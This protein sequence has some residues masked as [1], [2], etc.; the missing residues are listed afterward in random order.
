MENKLP[1]LYTIDVFRVF[2]SAF[3]LLS[4][5]FQAGLGVGD[6]DKDDNEDDE[7]DDSEGEEEQDGEKLTNGTDKYRFVD[8][9]FC[10]KPP[11]HYS[12][13]TDSF[14]F[15]LQIHWLFN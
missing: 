15:F 4:C 2:F 10:Q 12:R 1:A 5:W 11:W 13:M 7:E 9:M 8:L 14:F 3:E 6:D